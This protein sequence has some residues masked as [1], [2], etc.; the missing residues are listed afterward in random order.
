MPT[1]NGATD[2]N[3]AAAQLSS[4]IQSEQSLPT[5][6]D[7]EEGHDA[8]EKGQEG[9]TETEYEAQETPSSEADTEE[10]KYKVKVDG[11]E[12]EVTLEELQKGYM[13]ESNYRNKTTALNK[14]REAVEQ[15]GA[16]IDA[17]LSEAADLI[18]SEIKS[19]DSAEMQELRELDPEKYLA[20]QE[21]IQKK[22]KK[23]EALR[24][25][26]E[27]EHKAR[28][29]KLISK[30]RD[31]L[32]DAFPEWKGDQELMARESKELLGALSNVGFSDG[33][34]SGIT[35]HRLFVVAKKL[36]Q[37]EA[38]QASKPESKKVTAKPKTAK[39]GVAK[40]G[41]DRKS[42]ALRQKWEILK[43]TGSRNAAMDLLSTPIN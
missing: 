3:S 10:Q 35:D 19:L 27:A 24:E 21:A 1:E 15:K 38:I 2:V 34:L 5:D 9:N 26:R 22:V 16:E 37:L 23:F 11:E 40:T 36:Q 6:E 33:E 28:Q 18:D 30:E 42:D 29:D 17:Q 32:F 20:K 25:K 13:M 8:L 4:L 7:K 41:E 43:K 39:P 12:L 14:E 31:L